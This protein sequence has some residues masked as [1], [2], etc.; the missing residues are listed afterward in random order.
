MSR[1]TATL[2]FT[3][4]AIWIA[5]VF[6]LVS[7]VTLTLAG[8]TRRRH[9]A[10]P[11]PALKTARSRAPEPRLRVPRESVLGQRQGS[12]EVHSRLMPAAARANSRPSPT[13]HCAISL[14][15]VR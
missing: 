15:S 6:V 3:L 11:R 14:A 9:C 8:A 7:G 4:V 12:R 1:Y 2:G 13:N 5:V 10:S